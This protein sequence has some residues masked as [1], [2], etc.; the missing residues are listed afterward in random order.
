MN[1]ATQYF[2]FS[3][4]LD[5]VAPIIS[6]V[7]TSYIGEKGA[8]ITWQTNEE[9]TSQVLWGTTASLGSSTTATT[10][11][12]TEHSV[13]LTGLTAATPY[14]YQVVSADRAGNSTSDSTTRIF[15]TT[16]TTVVEVQPD[17]SA[18]GL[19]DEV[20]TAL[21]SIIET[22]SKSILGAVFNAIKK[23]PNLS[24]MS[25][26][27]VV[28]LVD[29]IADE[30][31]A[32]PTI[33]GAELGVEPSATS[34]VISWT[35]NKSANSLVAYVADSEHDSASANPYK[36]EVGNSSATTTHTVTLEGVEPETT[37]HFQ[38]RSKTSYGP[39]A[40][41]AD[42]IFKTAPLTP[43]IADVKIEKIMETGASFVWSTNIPTRSKV[44]LTEIASSEIIVQEL[45]NFTRDHSYEADQLSPSSSYTAQITSI[46]EDGKS[47]EPSTLSFFTTSSDKPPEISDVRAVTSLIP[48][49]V[50]QVQ[51][52]ISWKTSKPA[53]AVVR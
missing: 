1:G 34:A 5:A 40:V 48:G 3:T 32:A 44:E 33:G 53:T 27:D 26:E 18:S 50:E 8:S 49:K 39:Q 30:S 31:L 35:T 36:N 52:I 38:T 2:S 28:S 9:A 17:L 46:D 12:E 24:S 11:Y 13:S 37:Y 25:E 45:P 22:A 42:N 29:E 21:S 4:T 23:N 51:T 20:S 14:Y 43:N 41:S 47:A 7:T 19:R 16:T 15:T 10:S 6:S